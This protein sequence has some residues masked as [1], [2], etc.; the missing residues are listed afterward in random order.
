M[1]TVSLNCHT[2][3]RRPS[4]L[5]VSLS[6]FL[7]L[8]TLSLL[9]TDQRCGRP[10]GVTFHLLEAG[11]PGPQDSKAMTEKRESSSHILRHVFEHQELG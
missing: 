2:G 10:A 9:D 8:V 5:A 1:L 7:L 3:G 11:T 6:V 4:F